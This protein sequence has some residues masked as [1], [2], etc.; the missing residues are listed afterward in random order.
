MKNTKKSFFDFTKLKPVTMLNQ[1][2]ALP[3]VLQVESADLRSQISV[4][5]AF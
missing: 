3:T 5:A 1:D 4:C 2:D